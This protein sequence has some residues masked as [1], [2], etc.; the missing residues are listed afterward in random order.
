M[1]LG[2]VPLIRLMECET[3]DFPLPLFQRFYPFEEVGQN[4]VHWRLDNPPRTLR[5]MG[6]L[7]L[8][9]V[10]IDV[11]SIRLW[12]LLEF[13]QSVPKDATGLGDIPLVHFVK[14]LP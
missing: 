9:V 3:E 12:G 13:F 6:K 5:V 11:H 14:P 4:K 10:R 8:D 7:V 1:N 2:Y